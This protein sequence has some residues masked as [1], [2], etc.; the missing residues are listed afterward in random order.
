MS[1]AETKG[2]NWRGI[3]EKFIILYACLLAIIIVICTGYMTSYHG[4]RNIFNLPLSVLQTAA[5]VA[6]L[7]YGLYKVG[8][9]ILRIIAWLVFSFLHLEF[10]FNPE[11]LQTQL[12]SMSITYCASVAMP[13]MGLLEADF[14][15]RAQAIF[16]RIAAYLYISAMSILMIVVA[17]GF[18]LKMNGVT[19]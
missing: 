12:V 8:F 15:T 2:I 13:L 1:M 11:S 17:Y 10:T 16:Y 4:W 3:E 18:W 9:T 5:I 14:S 6:F 7:E 19:Y